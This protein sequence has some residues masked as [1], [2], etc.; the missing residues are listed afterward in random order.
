MDSFTTISNHTVDSAAFVKFEVPDV[1]QWSIGFVYH[2]SF[3]F[4]Y[5][6]ATY[7][8]SDATDDVFVR[9]FTRNDGEILHDLPRK[10]I[11]SSVLREG[12]NELAFRTSSDG[13][14]LRLNEETVIEVPVSQSNRKIGWSELCVGFR[15]AEE[16]PYAIPYSD[17]RTRFRREG[18]SGS[19]T[20]NDPTD[21]ESGCPMSTSNHAFFGSAIDSW[22]VLDFILP[23][24]EKWSVGFLYH[25]QGGQNSRMTVSGRGGS[26]VVSHFNYDD[27]ESHQIMAE[28]IPNSLLNTGS[29]QKNRL[30]FETTQ[31]GSSLFVN[32]EMVIV[33]PS[34]QLRRLLGS[35]SFCAHVRSDEPETYTIHFSNLWAWG[36]NYAN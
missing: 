21:D 18:G 8:Y 25:R 33:V 34:E 30:E 35:I 10:R 4:E 6:T 17:L 3:L 28:A 31:Y 1:R 5:M 16:V 15:A 2:S 20:H 29:G 36:W 7:I 9:H 22:V 24:V 11:S 32:G 26:Y 27:G 19:V 12:P 23:D 14:F 13:S